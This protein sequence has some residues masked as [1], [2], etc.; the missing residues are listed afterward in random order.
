MRDLNVIP[1][2][3]LREQ[4]TNSEWIICSQERDWECVRVGSPMA[5]MDSNFEYCTQYVY[6]INYMSIS[7]G[8]HR[9]Y[10]GQYMAAVSQTFCLLTTG[11]WF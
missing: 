4:E 5:D 2:T 9:K 10:K 8:I 11:Q 6:C 3:L 1:K 7:F